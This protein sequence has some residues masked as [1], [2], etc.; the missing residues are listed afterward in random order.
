VG[1]DGRE[2]DSC[3][4]HKIE[5]NKAFVITIFEHEDN[6]FATMTMNTRD[7]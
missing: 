4:I 6:F 1:N 2:N 5:I 3:E 7:S